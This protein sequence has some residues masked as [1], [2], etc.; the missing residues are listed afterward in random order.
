MT[1]FTKTRI[2]LL[3]LSVLACTLAEPS[4]SHAEPITPVVD[5]LDQ[6][7]LA[8][9]SE[10]EAAFSRGMALAGVDEIAAREA[11]SESADGWKRVIASGL[12]NGY[13]WTNL[14]NAEFRADRLGDAVAAYLEADRL[15]P[16]NGTVR[17]NLAEAR[18]N[19]PARFDSEGVIV[20]Y[21]TVSDGWH[22]LGFNTRWWIAVISWVTFWTI[23]AAWLF[24]RRQESD[25]DEGR[26]IAW[27]GT[28]ALLGVIALISGT[29][30]TF[31]VMEDSWRAPGVLIEESMVRTGNGETFK[32]VF[33]ESLPAGVEVD[34]IETRPG[35]HHVRFADGR[36]GWIRSDH[37]RVIGS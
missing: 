10:A 4:V 16:G 12:T 27:R 31:D 1:F 19:V 30:V 14:G 32:E 24:R 21:D 22:V 29:T 23:L 3:S 2:C 17:A 9:M 35:W 33:S 18:N 8:I 25:A 11:F 15:D 7:R 37:V 5:Q 26:T 20:L 13:V 36:D 28:L 34:L 6:E